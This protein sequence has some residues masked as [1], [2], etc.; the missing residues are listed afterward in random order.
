MCRS[1]STD[2][3]DSA[4]SLLL[5]LVLILVLILILVPILVRF[6]VLVLILVL[7]LALILI[8]V[9]ILVLVLLSQG[10]STARIP[11][12]HGPQRGR[13]RLTERLHIELPW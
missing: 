9:L 8:L 7:V 4:V 5:L 13:H 10:G 6:L 3:G 2:R 1:C 11:A 12:S